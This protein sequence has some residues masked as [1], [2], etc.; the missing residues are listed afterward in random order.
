MLHEKGMVLAY[1]QYPEQIVSSGRFQV[2]VVPTWYYPGNT[3]SWFK[4]KLENQ[5][6]EHEGLLE[7]IKQYYNSKQQDMKFDFSIQGRDFTRITIVFKHFEQYKRGIKIKYQNQINDYALIYREDDDKNILIAKQNVFYIINKFLNIPRFV[8]IL[9]VMDICPIQD[10]C[11]SKEVI[12]KFR[13]EIK[14]RKFIFYIRRN[15]EG[16]HKGWGMINKDWAVDDF[17]EDREIVQLDLR[18][19]YY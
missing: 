4:V 14:E 10:A 16:M 18:N 6:R 13:I 5:I 12:D 15:V 8:I 7:N 3:S 11:W 1:V 9:S 2:L 19:N 17:L